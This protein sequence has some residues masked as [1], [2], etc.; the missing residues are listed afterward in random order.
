MIQA[1]VGDWQGRPWHRTQVRN[2]PGADVLDCQVSN[3]S[4]AQALGARCGVRPE[5]KAAVN[6][7][8]VK[9]SDQLQI[10][11]LTRRARTRRLLVAA[12]IAVAAGLVLAYA[13]RPKSEA[14]LYRFDRALRRTIVQLIETTGS[15]EVRSRIEVPAPVAARLTSIS[16]RV[17]EEVKEGQLL[18]TLDERSA[19]FALR[20]AEVSA[21]AAGGRVAQARTAVA[22]AQQ[23][24][25]RT[26]RLRDKGLASE[27]E[28]LTASTALDQA[29]AALEGARA[30]KK[31][32]GEGV[33]SARL[34]RTLRQ[35]VAPVSGVVLHAPEEVGSVVAP[36][37]PLFV[38]AAPLSV[39]R[40]EAQVSE[41]EIASV[42]PGRKAE[43]LVQAL[44]GKTFEATVERIGIEP[45]REGGVVLYPVTLLVQN[46]DGGL[47]PGMS[48]RVRME[49]DR[50]D[51]ALSVHEAAV[52]FS[53]PEVERV[54]KARVWRRAGGSN[55]LEPVDVTT[56]VSDG[57][58][59]AVKAAAGAQL[60]ER[61]EVAI[62]LLQP[63]QTGGKPSVSLGQK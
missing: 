7:H 20:S 33:A 14:P 49:V 23:T 4:P 26:R 29:S 21:E 10:P 63:G 8:P 1:S 3:L 40:V 17:R 15:V 12:A 58:Y 53:P 50:V 24:V 35:I 57:V 48:A 41:T 54:A 44:P 30:D 22:S 28:L 19:E 31:L 2:G 36:E 51:G 61:D 43:V 11:D 52:R 32:A 42:A 25:A 45:R 59:V 55:Q 46:G 18:A 60:N 13:L 62:G 27:Q 39:M 47:L 38:I 9:G 5:Y 56:G 37:R 6:D 16:V 34:Q